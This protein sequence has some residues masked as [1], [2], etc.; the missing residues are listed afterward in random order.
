MEYLKY[1]KTSKIGTQFLKQLSTN[2]TNYELNILVDYINNNYNDK[3]YEYQ[4][5]KIIFVLDKLYG[6]LNKEYNSNERVFT[7]DISDICEHLL[8]YKSIIYDYISDGKLDEDF[9]QPNIDNLPYADILHNNNDE[10]LIIGELLDFQD[11]YNNEPSNNIYNKKILYNDNKEYPK[12]NKT[13]NRLNNKNQNGEEEKIN[14]K[15]NDDVYVG[16]SNKFNKTNNNN[17][18]TNKFDKMDKQNKNNTIQNSNTYTNSNIFDK[19]SNNDTYIDEFKKMSIQNNN[20]NTNEFKN[21][22]IQNNNQNTYKFNKMSIQNNKMSIQNNNKNAYKFNN[23]S[24]QNNEEEKINVNKSNKVYIQDEIAESLKNFRVD[25]YDIFV[26]NKD[27]WEEKIFKKSIYKLED[28]RSSAL[29]SL[30]LEKKIAEKYK[31]QFTEM[32][33][34]IN[35][36]LG[37]QINSKKKSNSNNIN[38]LFH[39]FGTFINEYIIIL[40]LLVN[41]DFKL[42]IYLSESSDILCDFIKNFNLNSNRITY[43]IIKNSNKCDIDI[44][45]IET[46]FVMINSLDNLEK[47][48][49]SFICNENYTNDVN[50][51]KNPDLLG[52][53]LIKSLTIQADLKKN[54]TLF[55]KLIK[56]IQESMNNT[57]FLYE[58]IQD[59]LENNN[60][61]SVDILID[62]LYKSI[63]FMYLYGYNN[64]Y[65]FIKE[66]KKVKVEINI[67]SDLGR[68]NYLNKGKRNNILLDMLYDILT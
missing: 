56:T 38:I 19:T 36:S 53:E 49:V 59:M 50:Q 3:Q 23:M 7:N 21:M 18:Y 66:Y 2:N 62:F 43:I 51:H 4:N 28:L 30:L 1:N 17:K 37:D 40:Y 54:K 5:D 26:T 45:N 29:N 34:M 63:I 25:H 60:F 52:R 47:I 9:W 48:D 31:D 20:Q 67:V 64:V 55:A 8:K 41:S 14:I 35:N 58:S 65:D 46:N 12:F 6:Q 42:N 33:K 61:G 16:K 57:K 44:D 68:L 24:I 27:I 15:N 39:A 32:T 13:V 22:S 10:N 11:R